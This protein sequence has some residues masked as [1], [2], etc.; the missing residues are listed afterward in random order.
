MITA[1]L[2]VCMCSAVFAIKV[3]L[4]NTKET[5]TR[6]AGSAVVVLLR[7]FLPSFSYSHQVTFSLYVAVSDTDDQTGK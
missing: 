3:R 2:F 5:G 6:A 4:F 7:N 1:Y